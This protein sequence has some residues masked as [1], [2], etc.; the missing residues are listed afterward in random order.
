MIRLQFVRP[1]LLNASYRKSCMAQ[2]NKVLTLVTAAGS[3]DRERRQSVNDP[4]VVTTR[5]EV[6]D[7]SRF[8]SLVR[9]SLP[10]A[11]LNANNL[12]SALIQSLAAF[13]VTL[14]NE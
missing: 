4:N 9:F 10:S 7:A 6:S 3:A 2:A 13:A 5:V 8:V 11:S 12:H 14:S 1:F